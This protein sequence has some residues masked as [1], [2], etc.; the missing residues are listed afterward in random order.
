MAQ[1]KIEYFYFAFAIE[2]V[3]VI[4]SDLSE[5]GSRDQLN[6]ELSQMYGP[7]SVEVQEFRV[8]TQEEI[9]SYNARKEQSQPYTVN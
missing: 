4:A 5:Q 2:R 1:T 6:R 8:A 9:D 3:G 7:D